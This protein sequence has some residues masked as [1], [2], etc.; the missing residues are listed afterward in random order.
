M[1]MKYLR[2]DTLTSVQAAHQYSN[3]ARKK[4]DTRL[5]FDKADQVP[6]LI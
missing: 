5:E 4:L 1:N 2:L 6:Q 3:H